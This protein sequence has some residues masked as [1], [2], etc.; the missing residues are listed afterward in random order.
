[1]RVSQDDVSRA[2]SLQSTNK[3]RA[4]INLFIGIEGKR[5]ADGRKAEG[6]V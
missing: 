5:I 2:H 3:G 1:M 6:V 4:E